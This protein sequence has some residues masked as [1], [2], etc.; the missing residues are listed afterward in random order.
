M[1]LI[2]KFPQDSQIIHYQYLQLQVVQTH[3]IG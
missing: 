3:C 1:R 2:E